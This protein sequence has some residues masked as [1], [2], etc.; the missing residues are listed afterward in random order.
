[1]IEAAIAKYKSRLKTVRVELGLARQQVLP[2]TELEKPETQSPERVALATIAR[3]V[4]NVTGIMMRIL[5]SLPGKY[6][7]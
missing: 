7:D 4:A 2:Y 5:D 6:E 3:A 1:M